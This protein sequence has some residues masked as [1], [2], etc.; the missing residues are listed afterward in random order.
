ME[1][2]K[3]IENNPTDV[4]E[5]FSAKRI[6]VTPGDFDNLK[7]TVIPMQEFE[8]PVFDE[9]PMV[10]ENNYFNDEYHVAAEENP[11]I[12][13]FEEP[14][15]VDQS[16]DFEEPENNDLSFA[17]ETAENDNDYYEENPIEA[18]YMKEDPAEEEPKSQISEWRDHVDRPSISS[19]SD[20]LAGSGLTYVSSTSSFTEEQLEEKINS[21]SGRAKDLAMERLEKIKSLNDEINASSAELNKSG[22]TINGLKTLE[23]YNNN[24]ADKLDEFYSKTEEINLD[25]IMKAATEA[26]IPIDKEVENYVNSIKALAGKKDNAIKNNEKIS[27]NLVKEEEIRNELTKVTEEKK[28]EKNG[29]LSKLPEEITTAQK[30]DSIAQKVAEL[31]EEK[32]KLLEQIGLDKEEPKKV[33]DI[34]NKFNSLRE[35]EEDKG[36]AK[37]A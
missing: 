14:I 2:Y 5:A 29:I 27:Q 31:E 24:F 12:D 35:T 25:E 7:S 23:G 15:V 22:D 21:L 34:T 28:E 8:A 13:A 6:K 16:N 3:V 10:E 9:E 32:R 11:A 26:G 1:K 37:A 36:Y 19:I 30:A 4:I 18:E 17:E 33:V 20:T